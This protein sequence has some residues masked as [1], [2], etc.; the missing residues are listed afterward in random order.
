[1]EETG[2]L[3][4][5]EVDIELRRMHFTSFTIFP[6]LSVKLEKSR[7]WAKNFI[8]GLLCAKHCRGALPIFLQF[9]TLR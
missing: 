6:S 9:N 5:S 8:N 1:M 2:R 3:V 4:G 7:K